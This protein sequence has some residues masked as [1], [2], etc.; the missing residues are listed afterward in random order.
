[1]RS[2]LFLLALV[3]ALA[4]SAPCAVRGAAEVDA[5]RTATFF[6]HE[7]G[8]NFFQSIVTAGIQQA[9]SNI[10]LPDVSTS[11]GGG[12]VTM[13]NIVMHSVQL[14]AQQVTLVSPNELSVSFSNIAGEVDLDWYFKGLL[15][16]HDHGTG[17]NQLSDTDFTYVIAFA[18]DDT[19]RPAWKLSSL[20][21]SIGDLDVTL[22]GGGSWLLNILIKVIKGIL[23]SQIESQVETIGTT[24]FTSVLGAI[25]TYY[26]M[27]ITMPAPLNHTQLNLPLSVEDPYTITGEYLV[28]GCDWWFQSTTNTTLDGGAHDTLP[29]TFPS[30]PTGAT[31][32]F[33]FGFDD[34][35]FNSLFFSMAQNGVFDFTIDNSLLPAGSA[36]ELTTKI[37]STEF[38]ALYAKYPGNNITFVVEQPYDL[39]PVITTTSAG[40]TWTN[41]ALVTLNVIDPSQDPEVVPICGINVHYNTTAMFGIVDNTTDTWYLTG[42]FA[43]VVISTDVA[44]ST[45][46]PGSFA[47]D[48]RGIMTAV[49]DY[50][51]LPLLNAGLAAGIPLPSTV[52]GLQMDNIF[53]TYVD[54]VANFGFDL[55][56]PQGGPDQALQNIIAAL[57]AATKN[58]TTTL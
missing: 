19:G 37:I 5:S 33:G 9:M 58:G 54:N 52:L 43:P 1:M 48:L 39:P 27:S 36:I 35:F 51:A 45:L 24:V 16:V 6:L 11:A 30:S 34:F 13:S 41:T 29:L 47:S 40:T 17:T 21:V 56:M 23:K 18:V 20:E 32:M 26:P 10:S 46:T 14:T 7:S 28:A 49:V 44:W 8:I 53:L 55:V 15:G 12:T 31:A 38:P 57:E 42:K 22:S 3:V 50:I 25:G 2:P 4:L